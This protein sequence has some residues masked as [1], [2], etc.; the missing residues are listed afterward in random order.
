MA[1]EKL[2]DRKQEIGVA[3]DGRYTVTKLATVN[4]W[5]RGGDLGH[6]R[7]T[8][9]Y[10]SVVHELNA[11][12]SALEIMSTGSYPSFFDKERGTQTKGQPE[13]DTNWRS[14]DTGA[15]G[16]LPLLRTKLHLPSASNRD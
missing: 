11:S 14:E 2:Q 3:P 1:K 4:R 16:A 10:L 13:R 5:A 9:T 6:K 12:L 15:L 8:D 7:I